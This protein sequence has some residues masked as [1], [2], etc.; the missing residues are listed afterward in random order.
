MHSLPMDEIHIWFCIPDQL[1]GREALQQ[2]RAVLDPGEQAACDRFRF[3]RHR[4]LYL[5][6]HALVRHALAA[7]MDQP[8]GDFAFARNRWGRPELALPEEPPLRFNLSHT[9]GLAACAICREGLLG[10]DVEGLART[11]ELGRRPDTIRLA[12]RF[13][14]PEEVSLLAGLPAAEQGRRFLEIWT[15]KEAYI[16][17]RG[18]GVALP[19]EK[20]AFCFPKP[21]RIAFRAEAAI[22][23][24]E[25]RWWFGLSETIPNFRL[26]IGW[27]PEDPGT[28][29][30]CPRVRFF[31]ALPLVSFD[32][33]TTPFLRTS[34]A[35]E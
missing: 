8:P 34:P 19:L 11:G 25:K 27:A 35:A 21:K 28:L 31:Q 10:V 16:K 9:E 5:V 24:D 2:C 32:E 22:E 7:Y 18:M 29:P 13:F 17:A 3:A 30:S 14:A 33:Q 20:F 4:H 23:P 15:L 6:S 1:A 26:S 12:K